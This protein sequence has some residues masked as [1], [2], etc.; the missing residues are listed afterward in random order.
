MPFFF[1][2]PPHVR[3]SVKNKRLISDTGKD[4]VQKTD[5]DLLLSLNMAAQAPTLPR[6]FLLVPKNAE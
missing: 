5:P 2:R 6:A 1:L 4:W 3:I